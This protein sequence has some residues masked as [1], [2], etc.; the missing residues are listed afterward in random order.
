MAGAHV[1]S[2]RLAR[3][4]FCNSRLESLTHIGFNGVCQVFGVVYF[5]SQETF[6]VCILSAALAT[7]AV[8][9]LYSYLQADSTYTFMQ[10]DPCVT[11]VV[12]ARDDVGLWLN[13]RLRDPGNLRR[14]T[15]LPNA[16]EALTRQLTFPAVVPQH[17]VPVLSF[18]TVPIVILT[19]IPWALYC[20][21]HRH[22]RRP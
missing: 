7:N 8:A 17:Y 12:R 10:S 21:M 20:F 22:D 11:V 9:Y 4:V 15:T 5:T 14:E 19:G 2:G 18:T 16:R 13:R 1:S 3:R 6:P